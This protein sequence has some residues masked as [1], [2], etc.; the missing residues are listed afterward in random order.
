MK[1]I[2]AQHYGVCFGVRDAIKQAEDL[3][4]LGELTI[5]GELVHNPIAKERLT[6][7]GAVESSLG[8]RSATTKKGMVTAHG[9]SDQAVAIWR[10]RGH[11][12]N[13]CNWPFVHQASS[14]WFDI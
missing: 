6:A 14:A 11:E 13:D 12:G 8:A 9:A 10:D 1:V 3:A 4:R 7:L 5:L 2:L